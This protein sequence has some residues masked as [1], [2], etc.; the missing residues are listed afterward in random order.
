MYVPVRT[1]AELGVGCITDD[2]TI[3]FR[4]QHL[5]K[6]YHR[7]LFRAKV[8]R[9]LADISVNAPVAKYDVVH[10]HFLYSDGAVA[11]KIKRQFERPFIVAVRNTDVNYFM[12]YRP[13]LA[14]IRD[15]V[16]RGASRVVF[17]SPAYRDAFIRRLPRPLGS[18]VE[19]KAMVVPNGIG[20]EWLADRA[21]ERRPL[22][23]PLRLLY[24]GDFT[25]NK[26]IRGVVLALRLL[27]ESM[28]TTLTV[29]GGGGDRKGAVAILLEHSRQHGINYLGRIDDR[30][31]LRAIYRCH[32]VLVMPSYRETF[33]LT[34][35]EALSQGVPIVHSKGQGVDGYFRPGT[36]AAAVNPRD[37]AS[38]AAG[39]LEVAARLPDVRAE[40]QREAQRFSWNEIARTYASTYQSIVGR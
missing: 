29:V 35:V 6:P 37:P 2:P 34:Y 18:D 7:L 19:S 13:D 8:R 4:F 1:A 32:D 22:Q 16:L 26:N 33:G 3:D 25:P 40:C 11:L 17:L 28:P 20:D 5:L 31:R 24:V 36:V 10:A 14:N 38:I 27:R 30:E 9:V 12:R 15:D 39:I 21:V 23:S